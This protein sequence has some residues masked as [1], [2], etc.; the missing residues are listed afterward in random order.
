[1]HASFLVCASFSGL[2]LALFGGVSGY[3]FY[4]IRVAEIRQ[5][6]RSG[7]RAFSAVV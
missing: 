7:S 6:H 1:V 5:R 4:S 3:C 2:V